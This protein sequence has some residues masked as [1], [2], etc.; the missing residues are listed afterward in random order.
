VQLATALDMDA[1]ALITHDRDFALV[2]GLPIL[3][4]GAG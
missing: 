1:A 2:Q 4:G 3:D